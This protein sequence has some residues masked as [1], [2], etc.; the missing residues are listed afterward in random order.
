MVAPLAMMGLSAAANAANGLV[1]T[2]NNALGATGT[3]A[4]AASAKTKKTAD[5][6]EKMFLENSLD[7]LVANTGEEGPLGENGTGG[8]VYKSMLVKEYAGEIV[9]TGG[10]GIAGQIYRQML[11]MQEKAN[12]G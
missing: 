10:V 5:D 2:I 8:S 9:K 11:Q 7:R 12:V 4:P 1:E 3:A 6:F